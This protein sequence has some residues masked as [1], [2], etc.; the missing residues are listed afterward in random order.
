MKDTECCDG[1]KRV[2]VHTLAVDAKGNVVRDADGAPKWITDSNAE[3]ESANADF[4][5]NDRASV[6]VE[7]RTTPTNT[8]GRKSCN[9]EE[10]HRLPTEYVFA[11]NEAVTTWHS[12]IGSSN[13][14]DI[15]FE[16]RAEVVPGSGYKLAQTMRVHAHARSGHGMGERGHTSATV[17]CRFFR[18][19]T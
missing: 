13:H 5:S 11:E 1:E 17:S 7:C 12:D 19:T 10:V 14:V 4:E 2:R 3:T 6:V 8:S 16:D 9:D 15:S 18:R